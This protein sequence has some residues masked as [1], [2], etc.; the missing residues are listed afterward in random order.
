MSL[1]LLMVLVLLHHPPSTELQLVDRHPDIFLLD[2]LLNLEFILAST[3]TS[4][5]GPE[6]AKDHYSLHHSSCL[7]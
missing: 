4:C 6:A 5:S 1:S 2:T 7:G 3:M